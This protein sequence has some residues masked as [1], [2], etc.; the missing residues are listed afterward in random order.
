MQG[1]ATQGVAKG[2]ASATSREFAPSGSRRST[3]SSGFNASERDFGFSAL[4]SAL[5]VP[6]SA[7]PGSTAP[8]PATT[9]LAAT[10]PT[11]TAP[12]ATSPTATAPA[13]TVLAAT[14]IAATTPAATAPAAITHATT[15]PSATA[16]AATL[17]EDLF[18]QYM[19]AYL[20]ERRNPASAPALAPPPADLREETSDRPLKASNP[21]LYYGNWHMEGYY[22]CQQFEDHFDT[23]GEEGYKRVLF[24][25]F[26]LKD[27]ILY[28]WQQHKASTKCS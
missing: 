11:A 7:A 9:A 12:S 19:Q 5:V 1:A 13:A 20:E 8:A 24:A 15:T 17:T 3:E 26:F 6:S 14:A 27:R 16:L 23:A 22:F 21:E 10:A 2:S 4:G 28:R 18:R 25:A